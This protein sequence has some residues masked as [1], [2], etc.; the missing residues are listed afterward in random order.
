ME[1]VMAESFVRVAY[2]LMALC[3][4]SL[5]QDCTKMLWPKGIFLNATDINF[6]IKH[7]FQM[8]WNFVWLQL[9]IAS[10]GLDF[11]GRIF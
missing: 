9:N 1:C 2:C 4:R 6:L 10:K 5:S 11:H 8:I 3:G 7:S